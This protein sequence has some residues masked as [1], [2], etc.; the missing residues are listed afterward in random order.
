MWFA[1]V[2]VCLII[3]M[4]A[5]LIVPCLVDRWVANSIKQLEE[6]EAAM[7]KACEDCQGSFDKMVKETIG[8]DYNQIP[9]EM[10]CTR[11]ANEDGFGREVPDCCE[12]PKGNCEAEE[13]DG[14]QGEE[15]P[16]P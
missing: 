2:L 15:P 7:H 12:L 8:M 1:N 4:V 9:E 6:S 14:P 5:L 16:S 13:A 11:K 3:L 10:W